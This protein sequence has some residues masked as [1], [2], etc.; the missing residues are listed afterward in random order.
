M[1]NI[2]KSGT[3]ATLFLKWTHKIN[4]SDFLAITHSALFIKTVA[5]IF[6]SI[7]NIAQ[8]TTVLRDQNKQWRVFKIVSR[9]SLRKTRA[10]IVFL[11]ILTLII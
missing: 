3:Y 5:T 6:G 10:K 1:G 4:Q 8:I 2:L 7:E 11:T 9:L